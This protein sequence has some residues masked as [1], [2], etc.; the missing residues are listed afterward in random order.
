MAASYPWKG[1]DSY[2]FA[3]RDVVVFFAAAELARG[4]A[5]AFAVEAGF[6]FAALAVFGLGL[7][8]P[9]PRAASMM[10]PSSPPEDVDLARVVVL[11]ER[12]VRPVFLSISLTTPLTT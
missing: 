10:E 9:L 4:F 6:F 12:P 3:L 5:G 8:V 7:A 11:G 1:S 2:V